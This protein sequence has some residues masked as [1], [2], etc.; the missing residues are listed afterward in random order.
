[1]NIQGRFFNPCEK[2]Y[3]LFG[4]RGTG[5]S[6]LVKNR[7]P[8]AVIF[9]LLD[10]ELHRQLLAHPNQLKAVVQAHPACHTFII[11]E[12]QKAPALLGIVH[13]LI[14][15]N[16]QWQFILTGSSARK[17]KREG[18]DLLA[19]RALLKHL[20]PFMAAEIKDD[21]NLEHNIKFGM[22]P[23]VLDS[24][25]P[26]TDLKT[27]LALYMREEVQIESLIRKFDEFSH[28]LE[29]MSFSQASTMNYTNIARECHISNK[30]VE[31]YVTILEDLLLSFRLPVFTKKEQRVLSHH[32]KF[33]YFDVGV[34]QTIRPK[35]LLDNK[36]SIV[37]H[38]L[39]TLVAQH[40]R[41]WLDYSSKEGKL[42]FW[43]TRTG[44]EV[45]FIIYG[46]IGF[47]AIE[48][49]ASK[50]VQAKDF[51]GLKEFH[52]DFPQA[53][54]L[55]LYGGEQRQFNHGILCMPIKEFLQGLIPSSFPE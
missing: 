43:R 49:K 45:D 47:Y 2:S 27:Y 9:D 21:F 17:L 54:C 14:E 5:K 33:Y 18:V 37:G 52:K 16:K 25:D 41:A 50:T 6:T 24:V 34:Y 40:L 31:N 30:T 7:Y 19:G 35:G 13:Q 46:E 20:H 48:V 44:L 4:P 38:A 29:V 26:L 23:L 10:P 51:R 22:L 36:Q 32:P 11:D 8:A 39:E 1:M 53:T 55:L 3:F 28:F 42:Y 12:V 15:S